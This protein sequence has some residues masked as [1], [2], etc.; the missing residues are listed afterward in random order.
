MWSLGLLI[1]HFE[2][3]EINVAGN[4]RCLVF[5]NYSLNY[6]Y[7]M[8]GIRPFPCQLCKYKSLLKLVHVRV[9]ICLIFL[10]LFLDILYTCIIPSSPATV[11]SP[12]IQKTTSYI[13]HH[14]TV[15]LDVI[16]GIW[17]HFL[18]DLQPYLK[19]R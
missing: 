1:I 18:P 13:D 6:V 16:L 12:H 10:L 14:L 9:Y 2:Y 15:V 17:T 4:F 3:L 5:I 19:Y 11:Q 8:M 7:V